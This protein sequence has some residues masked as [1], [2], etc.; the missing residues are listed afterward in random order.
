MYVER[1]RGEMGLIKCKRS[2]KLE[3][4]NIARYANHA[5]EA[6]LPDCLTWNMA[7][8]NTIQALENE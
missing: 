6:L 4:N 7:K 5:I 2:A 8:T 1:N 3:E